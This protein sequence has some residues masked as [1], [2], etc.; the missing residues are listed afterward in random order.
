MSEIKPTHV[1]RPVGTGRGGAV[2][3]PD[4]PTEP[5]QGPRSTDCTGRAAAP[6]PIKVPPE[7]TPGAG[8]AS[9]TRPPRRLLIA[10]VVVVVL[11]LAGVSGIERARSSRSADGTAEPSAATPRRPPRVPGRSGDGPSMASQVAALEERV[12]RLPEDYVAWASLGIA[13]VQ[14]ARISADP[15]LYGRAEGA[16]DR[17]LKIDDT[18]NFV[19]YAGRS[20][21]A[22]AQH[23][24]ADAKQ[25]ALKGLAIN[26]YNAVLYGALSD[27]EI[28]LGEYSAA[29]DHVQRMLEISPD[30][31]S[32]ARASYI[33]ELRGDTA[34]AELLMQQAHAAAPTGD[35]KASALYYLGDLA[36][37]QGDAN[38]A[39]EHYLDALEAAPDYVLAQAGRAKALAATGQTQAA[40]DAYA[41]V[42]D[43]VPDPLYVIPYGR[44]LERQGRIGDAGEQYRVAGVAWKLYEANGVEPDADQILFVA[45]KGDPQEALRIAE[46]AVAARPF[47][48]IQDAYAW[49]LYRNGRYDDAERAVEA[50]LQLGTRSAQFHF[51]AGM[52]QLAKGARDA[53]RTELAAAMAINPNFD[54]IDARIA[55]T[56]LAELGAR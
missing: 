47:L 45:D 14:Q 37:D 41:E 21:L 10:A 39:L 1:P 3:A 38:A 46:T 9:P 5:D 49:A 16:L 42:V 2:A 12:A 8:E 34:R 50:A 11:V 28:Q 30:A 53:A 56:T 7:P 43:R 29:A 26:D 25:F 32:Y 51:H 19:A 27:A 48:A 4:D 17:S 31:S 18:Q 35:D 15:S 20:N 23:R 13:Y 52:I 55:A 40:L 44:L 33:A 24:F 6:R 22:G 54:P 36:F